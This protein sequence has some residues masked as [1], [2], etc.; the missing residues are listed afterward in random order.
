MKKTLKALLFAPVTTIVAIGFVNEVDALTLGFCES[1]S[2]FRFQQGL[3]DGSANLNLTQKILQIKKWRDQSAIFTLYD[4]QVGNNQKSWGWT[5]SRANI[6]DIKDRYQALTSKQLIL[7]SMSG[8]QQKY[9]ALILPQQYNASCNG[10]DLTEF[11]SYDYLPQFFNN[12]KQRF[13]DNILQK[14]KARIYYSLRRIVEI[15]MQPGWTFLSMVLDDKNNIRHHLMEIYSAICKVLQRNDDNEISDIYKIFDTS[16]FIFLDDSKSL[17]CDQYGWNQENKRLIL[18]TIAEEIHRLLTVQSEQEF[19]NLLGKPVIYQGIDPSGGL[20]V[21]GSMKEFGKQIPIP[22]TDNPIDTDSYI[23][24]LR[25]AAMQRVTTITS[26]D[27]VARNLECQKVLLEKGITVQ[28]YIRGTEPGK[29][30]NVAQISEF[31]REQFPKEDFGGIINRLQYSD[32][33]QGP[34]QIKENNVFGQGMNKLVQQAGTTESKDP[35]QTW[36]DRQKEE[37][38]NADDEMM[39]NEM[40]NKNIQ[41]IEPIE[42]PKNEIGNN[43]NNSNNMNTNSYNIN[44][45]KFDPKENYDFDSNNYTQMMVNKSLQKPRILDSNSFRTIDDI[46]DEYIQDNTMAF[47]TPQ[48]VKHKPMYNQNINNNMNSQNNMNNSFQGNINNMNNMSMNSQY[49]SQNN[50]NYINNM[51]I[52]PSGATQ[53][54]PEEQQ[55]LQRHENWARAFSKN[56]NFRVSSAE[57]IRWKQ[58]Y[59]KQQTLLQNK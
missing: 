23:A 38:K 50:L 5:G 35:V 16:S 52:N 41:D 57:F 21:F 39:T 4:E 10:A 53:L 44:N 12:L 13:E 37:D 14:N 25:N 28:D 7:K 33:H 6:Q 56:P 30:D 11:V 8:D 43:S 24:S 47:S 51:N 48:I 27:L 17:Y 40:M 3:T 58:A 20:N 18:G 19:N 31:I 55:L 29:I 54:S 32:M 49:N 26:H 34:M 1:R 46:P 22:V 2:A 42:L 9:Y 45:L 59:I 36:L 15:D